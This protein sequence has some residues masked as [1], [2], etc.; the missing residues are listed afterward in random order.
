V[1]E[2]VSINLHSITLVC[3]QRWSDISLC[4]LP[5]VSVSLCDLRTSTKC[6]PS[7]QFGCS[8]TQRK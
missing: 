6:H 3:Q 1:L 8:T 7:P 2:F 5:N 4:V